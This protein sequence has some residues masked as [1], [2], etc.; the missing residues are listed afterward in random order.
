MKTHTDWVRNPAKTV[1]RFQC[2]ALPPANLKYFLGQSAQKSEFAG[3]IK[4][5]TQ[6]PI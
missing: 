4:D 3:L 2:S 6:N 1:F 5:E